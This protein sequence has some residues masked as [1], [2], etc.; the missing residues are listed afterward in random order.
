MHGCRLA[1]HALPLAH[2]LA[3]ALP[4]SLVLG[5]GGDSNQR[6]CYCDADGGTHELDLPERFRRAPPDSVGGDC[7]G[8]VSVRLP[9]RER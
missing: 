3:H 4:V 5:G 2:A 6:Q 7:G 8:G 9:V 1:L